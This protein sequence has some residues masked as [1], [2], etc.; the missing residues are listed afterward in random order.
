M[1]NSG[2]R[3]T[4]TE[5]LPKSYNSR[6]PTETQQ[7]SDAGPPGGASEGGAAAGVLGE[8]IA[9][10]LR[11]AE[12]LRP[13]RS[14]LEQRAR[15][16]GAPPSMV[17][18]LRREDV[19]VIAEIKRASPSQGSI[20]P[21]LDAAAQ[22]VA[23]A[24]GGAAAISVLTEPLR[25][26]GSLTDLETTSGAVTIPLLRKDFVLAEEQVL[27]ARIA[28]ASAV[29]LIARALRRERLLELA[30]FCRASGVEPLVEVRTSRELA[31]A[32][33]AGALLVGINA[34]DLETLEVDPRVVPRIAALV[35]R[36]CVCIAE[37]GM[38]DRSDV[39]AVAEHGVDAV[40]MG[41]ALS[42]AP[43]PASAVRAITGVERRQRA[44]RD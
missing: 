10:A 28:G 33:S 21:G 41:S 27:E 3:E 44:A 39:E 37:S 8:L 42:A 9:A 30:A 43:D 12:L 24:R 6:T 38:R 13:R 34:R 26:S 35:P 29:L 32:L 36:D 31:V 25:F 5:D 7:R 14:E 23:Y 18:A 2:C 40:L 4:A 1:I 15:D 17:R 22:A 11:R 16:A 19:A 20:N